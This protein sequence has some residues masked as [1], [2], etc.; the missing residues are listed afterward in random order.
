MKR[1][2]AALAL[3]A[4]FCGGVGAQDEATPPW[5][6]KFRHGPLD[7]YTLTYKDG[8]ATTFYYMT[9]T[10]ENVSKAP[11]KLSLHFKAEVVVNRRKHRTHIAIPTPDAEEAIR[12]IAR[13]PDL[14]NVQQINK[15]GEL[16]PGASVG[17]IAVLGTFNREWATAKILVSGL[18][19]AALNCRVRKYEGVGHT[20]FHRAYL[21]HN[22]AVLKKVASDTNYT[23]VNAIVKHDVVWVMNYH[24]EGDEFAPQI[25]PIILDS[26][27]WDV[28]SSTI[29]MEKKPP[30]PKE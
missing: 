24:R 3:F 27:Y 9:F 18:E 12:R 7:T 22:Q 2:L 19:S 6:L 15:M 23:E 16:A 21:R 11:A 8:S 14:K 26:E 5:Q 10:L 1:T 13:S 20:I 4:L 29:V 25:D 17:G 28:L 30:I